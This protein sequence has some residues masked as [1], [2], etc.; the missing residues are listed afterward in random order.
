MRKSFLILLFFVLLSGCSHK[1]DVK[2]LV[3]KNLVPFDGFSYDNVSVKRV[4][5]E[6]IV[7]AKCKD[8]DGEDEYIFRYENGTLRL[9]SYCLE[10]LPISLKYEAVS[11]ALSNET[12]SKNARGVV[13]VRRI[14]PDTAAKFYEPKELLSVTWWENGNAVVSALID[15]DEKVVVRVFKAQRSFQ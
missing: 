4:G 10:A 6:I 8:L 15:P 9:V 11:I 3:E 1:A 5:N 12:V 7:K 14:L 2:T 13:T